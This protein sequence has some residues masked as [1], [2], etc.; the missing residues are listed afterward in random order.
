MN[1]WPD[2]PPNTIDF[3]KLK[4]AQ[5]QAYKD[6]FMASIDGRIAGLHGA[7]TSVSAFKT[8]EPD[9][10]RD[11]LKLLGEWFLKNVK[12]RSLTESEIQ[13]IK[14]STPYDFGVPQDTLTEESFW[15][16]FDIGM[17]FGKTFASNFQ[18]LRWVQYIE[19]KR[20][21][22]FGH[23][24]LTGF[25]TMV[26]NPVHLMTIVAHGFGSGWYGG[27]RIHEVYCIW[28]KKVSPD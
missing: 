24:C 4:K 28:E 12:T 6:W 17:Y 8:W 14:S 5:L 16:A 11:S 9:Y 23:I 10:S 26:M 19:S 27:D 15:L 13:A 1:Y 22:D 3:S 25:G 7:V 21:I 2:R 20:N 18:R